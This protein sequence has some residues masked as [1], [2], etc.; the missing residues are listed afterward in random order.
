MIQ[1]HTHLPI[2]AL[3]NYTRTLPRLPLLTSGTPPIRQSNNFTKRLKLVTLVI[4]I[5]DFYARFLS[6]LEIVRTEGDVCLLGTAA[7]DTWAEGCG[8]RTGG[9]GWVGRGKGR[10][11]CC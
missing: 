4:K 6:P 3:P 2:L 5:S 1:L 11:R 8:A 10:C 7:G 9:C